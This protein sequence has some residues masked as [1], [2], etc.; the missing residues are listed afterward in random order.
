MDTPGFDDLSI[1]DAD[2]LK[3]ITT[4]LV[5]AFRDNADIHGAL[6]I[7]SL[8]ETRMRG[9][10]R[11]N[12]IMFRRMLGTKGMAKCRLVTTKWSLQSDSVSIDREQELCEKDEFWKPLLDAGAQTMR[13][14]DSVESAISIIKPLIDSPAFKPLIVKEIVDQNKPLLQ[15]K[16]GQVVNDDLEEARNNHKAEIAE[17]EEEKKRAI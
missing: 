2:I 13:F 15:T 17:L 4:S 12:L 14:N 10:G 11:K 3:T 6:Y 9:S 16:A 5:D 8:T 1:S 7:H